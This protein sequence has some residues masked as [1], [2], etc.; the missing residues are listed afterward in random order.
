MESRRATHSPFRDGPSDSVRERGKEPTH[1]RIRLERG[2]RVPDSGADY[3]SAVG[4][5]MLI[6]VT[7]EHVGGQL[8]KG[9]NSGLA[10]QET[11]KM[12]RATGRC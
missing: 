9:A 5:P 2:S 11:E 10:A 7:R 3:C 4:E 8:P 12:E 1:R 6:S